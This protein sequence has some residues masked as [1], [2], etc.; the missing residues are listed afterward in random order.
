MKEDLSEEDLEKMVN[1]IVVITFYKVVGR[2]YYRLELNR[3][4][5]SFGHLKLSRSYYYFY[6][7]MYFLAIFD[8]Y[9]VFLIFQNEV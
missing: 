4:L 2:S 1:F 3:P 8:E 5:V 7:N 9:L 6:S